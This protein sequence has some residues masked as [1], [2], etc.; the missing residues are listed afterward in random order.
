MVLIYVFCLQELP[1]EPE[2]LKQKR[3]MVLPMITSSSCLMM[4]MVRCFYIFKTLN[5]THLLS[6][7]GFFC[8]L[9]IPKR[10][11]KNQFLKIMRFVKKILSSCQEIK[12]QITIRMLKESSLR[13]FKSCL[14]ILIHFYT[15]CKFF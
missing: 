7:L 9:L 3:V 14:I 5:I 11:V 12:E 6:S 1:I 13:I 10:Y 2:D 4:F 8:L 15:S